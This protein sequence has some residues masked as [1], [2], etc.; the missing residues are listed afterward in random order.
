MRSG[1]VF[2]LVS[3]AALG[4]ARREPSPSAAAAVLP[5]AAPLSGTLPRYP[6]KE[7]HDLASDRGSVV[8]LD[9]WATWCEPCKDTLPIYGSL[10]RDLSGK[11][12]KIYA[13]NVDE[14]VRQLE[15]FLESA[16]VA[17]PILLDQDAAY[18]GQV[19][20]VSMMPSS[21]I[22]DREGKLRHVHEGFAQGFAAQLRG[23][24]EALL[25]P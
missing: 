11:G 21:F 1:L 13:I 5:R 17:I 15:P 25:V 19:L 22:Y 7:P 8:V 12:L 23:E 10:L 24:L 4:C 18:S 9:V 16:P 14:D 3:C 20:G 6:G 2:A